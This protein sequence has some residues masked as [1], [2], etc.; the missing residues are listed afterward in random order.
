M[1]VELKIPSPGESINEVVIAEWLKQVGQSVRADEPVVEIDTD[2]VSMSIAAP[3]TGTVSKIIPSEGDTVAVGDVVALIEEGEVSDDEPPSGESKGDSKPDDTESDPKPAKASSNG[4]SKAESNADARVMPSARRAMVK[5][6]LSDDDV[7]GTG[8]GGRV[9]KEDVQRALANP[10][11][12]G[13]DAREIERVPMSTL[14]KRIATRLVESQQTAAILTTFN[15]VDMTEVKNLRK[16]YKE[17]FHDRHGVKLGFMSFF[18]KAAVDALKLIPGV[19][20]KIDDD[21]IEY[22]NYQDIGIAVG[23][24]KGL[25]VPVIRNA[26]RMSFAE[27]EATIGDFGER[28]QKNRITPD[29]LAGGTFTISNGGVYGSLLSTPIINPPQSGILGLHGIQDRPVVIDGEIVIRPMMYV[30][31]SYDHR[32]VDGREA[33][34]FLKRIK[35]CIENPAR[36]LM[37][38]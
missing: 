11:A 33:V 8:P 34:T 15:E 13:A 29:E 26:E 9:L 4:S 18:V 2:K 28:A 23:G 14:R 36:M 6:N 19:N 16:Q 30:A 38:I 3:V 37:E 22:H 12:S 35:E 17:S 27:I 1:A 10:S 21:H 20:A 7:K 32:L 24:G 5:N 25:V 31:L